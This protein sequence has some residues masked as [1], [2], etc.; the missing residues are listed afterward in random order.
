MS[1]LQGKKSLARFNHRKRDKSKIADEKREENAK[2]KKAKTHANRIQQVVLSDVLWTNPLHGSLFPSPGLSPPDEA[3]A[4]LL[5]NVLLMQSLASNCNDASVRHRS[6]THASSAGLGTMKIWTHVVSFRLAGSHAL[7]KTTP[8]S[9]FTTR[10]ERWRPASKT[11]SRKRGVHLLSSCLHSR[12]NLL[13]TL[14]T[15]AAS[16]S[17]PRLLVRSPPPGSPG[18][19]LSQDENKETD[20][21]EDDEETD[22]EFFKTCNLPE[23]CC[24]NHCSHAL[25]STLDNM[26]DGTCKAE[27][28]LQ[29]S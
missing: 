19:L 20:Q 4:H 7:V 23:T 2:S 26:A 12:A 28:K 24:F 25:H 21:H 14:Q 13:L 1:I 15:C 5:A 9:V 18:S 10:L 27:I 16:S 6:T 22:L 17:P 3:C 29:K 8:L 11:C